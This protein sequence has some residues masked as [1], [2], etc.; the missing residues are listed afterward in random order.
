MIITKGTLCVRGVH[1]GRTRQGAND[2][3]KKSELDVCGKRK[4]VK[5]AHVNNCNIT[6]EIYFTVQGVQHF[7]ATSPKGQNQPHMRF[8]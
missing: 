6:L 8:R 2:K 3:K 4:Y 7:F 1:H 5:Y